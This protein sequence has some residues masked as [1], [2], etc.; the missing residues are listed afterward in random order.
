MQELREHVTALA[1]DIG[2]RNVWRYRELRRSVDY[3]EAVF[4]GAGYSPARQTY[5]VSRLPVSNIEVTLRGAAKPDE[6]I[7]LGAHYDTV[8]GS[9]GANDNGTG[10]AALLELAR[11]FSGRAQ[12]RTIRFVAFVNE[13][14]PFFQ[15][16]Q[17]GSVVYATAAK[18]RGD[19]I[20]GML[21]LETM[22]Y[23]S[24]ESGSQQYPVEEMAALFPAVGNFIGFVSNQESRELLVDAARAFR[25]RATLPVQAAA[26]PAGLPGAGWSDH[27][28]FW[29]A[30]YPAL[31]VTD[32]AP[33][34]YPWYH[35]A[36]DTP[37][38]I[39]FAKLVEVVDGLEHVVGSLAG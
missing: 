12:P 21:S 13:E 35:T 34:R 24:D 29:Q 5:D 17:M 3:L 16:P 36:D 2:E 37:D 22:G 10:V 27:W 25:E 14:P 15:T 1:A 23:F 9:P 32:T 19:R 38:K 4:L 33:W 30:G 6:I 11:R 7:L 31:M 20:V 28:S 26:M 8:G 39:D 18:E